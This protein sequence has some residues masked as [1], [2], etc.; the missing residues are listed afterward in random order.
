MAETNGLLNRR[1]GKSG[2]EGSNPSVSAIIPISVNSPA[3]PHLLADGGF[4]GS[5]SSKADK[6]RLVGTR[7]GKRARCAVSDRP[8]I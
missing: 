6:K 8:V 7:I 2:T 3:T 5:N 1:T 4:S